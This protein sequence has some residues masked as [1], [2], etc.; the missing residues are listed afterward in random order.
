MTAWETLLACGIT[1]LPVDLEQICK[2]LG[3][4]LFSYT[5][6]YR[7]LQKNRLTQVSHGADGFLLR[8]QGS[9]IILYNPHLIPG[10]RRF[11]IAHE[12]GHFCLGH[13]EEEVVIHRTA[14][15]VKS[16][17]PQEIEADRFASQLLA[18]TCILRNLGVRS[19]AAIR[20][21]CHISAQAAEVC[22]GRLMRMEALDAQWM[23]QWGRPYYF[24]SSTERALCRQFEAFIQAERAT[25]RRLLAP[26]A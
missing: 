12:I 10:R 3:L 5:Q 1:Q 19:P 23:A 14:D 20:Q 21:T 17:T 16:R 9:A 7:I 2:T 6:G 24:Q 15:R 4:S 18:P 25:I 8:C 11:T 22:L 26:R 13:G